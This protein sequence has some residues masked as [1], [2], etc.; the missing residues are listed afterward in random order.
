MLKYSIFIHLIISPSKATLYFAMGLQSAILTPIAAVLQVI[1]NIHMHCFD[2]HH[3]L[4]AGYC[5]ALVR[6]K[7]HPG[8]SDWTQVLH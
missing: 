1:D 4:F 2:K 3:D 5:F 6:Y 8:R 7:L